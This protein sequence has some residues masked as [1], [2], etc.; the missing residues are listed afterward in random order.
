MIDAIFSQPN[1]LAAKKMLDAAVVRHDAIAS[2][3]ANLETPGYQRL[4]LAPS[5]N[6]E[7]H[8]ATTSQD[9]AQIAGLHP[10]VGVDASAAALSHD[11]NTVSLEN[12]ILQLNQNALEHSLETQLI[13]GSLL[14]LRLA[15]T[16]KSV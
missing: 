9:P 14:K 1:Y 16:G 10:A 4:D 6:S 13:T 15:I 3:I 12:E 7:L 5:F 2:N 8:R 11:G